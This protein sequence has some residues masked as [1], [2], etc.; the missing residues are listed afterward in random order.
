[1]V[2][3]ST[4]VSLGINELIYSPTW[5]ANFMGH[6]YVIHKVVYTLLSLDEIVQTSKDSP[7]ERNPM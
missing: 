5:V 3:K 1:M 4:D 2:V 7:L 6:Y